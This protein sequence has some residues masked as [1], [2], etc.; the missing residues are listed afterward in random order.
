MSG[1]SKKDHIPGSTAGAVE[2]DPQSMAALDAP[3]NRRLREFYEYWDSKRSGAGGIPRRDAV[4]PIDIP[5]LLPNMFMA[6]VVTDDGRVRFCFRL[7]GTEIVEKEGADFTGAFLDELNTDPESAMRRQYE[8]VYLGRRYYVRDDTV[9]WQDREHVN[10][11]ILIL[12][13]SSGGGAITRLTGI[14]VYDG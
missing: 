9:Y 5:R 13:L 11:R 10:Y 2:L 8:D 3:E 4:D 1:P 7:V 14:A 12:P 6:E